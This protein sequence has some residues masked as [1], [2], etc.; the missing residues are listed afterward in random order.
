MPVIG[1]IP[2]MHASPD[3]FIPLQKVYAD[4]A[5]ADRNMIWEILMNQMKQRGVAVEG[6]GINRAQFDTFC[7]CSRNFRVFNMNSIHQELEAPNCGDIQNAIYDERNNWRWLVTVR[8]Y[9]AARMTKPDIGVK[10][11]DEA[12]LAALQA[13]VAKQ[14]QLL[15]VN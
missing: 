8:A 2:D 11:N 10:V 12:D 3:V 14:N 4:K 15:G 13:E 1:I 6:S 5:M 9:E 7:K